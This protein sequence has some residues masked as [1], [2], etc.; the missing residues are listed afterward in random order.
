VSAAGRTE[1]LLARDGTVRYQERMTTVPTDVIVPVYGAF[2]HVVRCVEHV[3]RFTRVPYRLIL[4]DDGNTDRRLLEFFAAQ[5]ELPDT[6]VLRNEQNRGFVASCNRAFRETR[7]HVVLLNSDVDVTDRWLEKMLRA[8]QA[9]ERTA[10]ITPLTNNGDLCSIPVFFADNRLPDGFSLSQFAALVEGAF[11]GTY[12]ELPTSVGF[13]MLLHRAA[14]DEVGAFDEETFGRGYGEE[15]D[16]CLRAA[17][18][19]WSN[20]LDPATYVYHHGGASFGAE[21]SEQSR[22]NYKKLCQRYPH[23]DRTIRAFRRLDPLRPIHDAIRDRLRAHYAAQSRPR[24]LFVVHQDVFGD[25]IGGTT[26]LVRDLM[27]H[28]SGIDFFILHAEREALVLTEVVA[29][30]PARRE[31]PIVPTG[32][33]ARENA[34]AVLL[35]RVLAEMAFDLIHV[36]HL[37][38]HEQ[39]VIDALIEHGAPTVVSINDFHVL[40]PQPLLVNHVEAYCGVPA[41]LTVCDTCLSVQS[42]YHG[43]DIRVHRARMRGLLAHARRV[44]FPSQFARQFVLSHFPEL[45]AK[46]VIIEHGTTL[47]AGAK[48]GPHRAGALDEPRVL[49]VAMLGSLAAHKG[50]YVVK[51]LITY[52]RNPYIEWH[53]MGGDVADLVLP[54]EVFGKVVSHGLYDREHVLRLLADQHIDVTLI[55]SI[56]AETFS[57]TLSESWLAGLPAI[58]SHFGALAE[59]VRTTDGGWIVNPYDFREILDLLSVLQGDRRQIEA[60]AANV[61]RIEVAS[62]ADCAARYAEQYLQILRTNS[63]QAPAK[64]A[65]SSAC[66]P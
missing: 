45:D 47:R 23:Y 54:R 33:D 32:S 49:R 41:D 63:T 7:G 8:L 26:L 65:S 1:G 5:A 53:L 21:T 27:R 60:K 39:T 14:L 56:C 13:C 34:Y 28:I 42:E 6:L 38:Y 44:F 4:V 48:V 35:R 31:Y 16:F 20:R 18:A 66:E 15:N 36:Q 43:M 9:N 19:G 2:E 17:A 62:S 40:C 50:R 29:G 37:L 30:A 52:N 57:F 12:P 61:E 25:V 55:P 22:S 64:E 46:S 3:R 10:T 24:L 59:R 11:L 58:V 51:N